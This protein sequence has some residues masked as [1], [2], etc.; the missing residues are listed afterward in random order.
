MILSGIISFLG[1]SAFRMVWGEVSAFLSK[2]Q[3]HAYEIERLKLQQQLDDAAHTRT[4]STIRLQAELGV[5][6]VQVQSA[7]E[8]EKASGDAFAAAMENA[9]KP[10]GNIVV[11]VWNGVI[12]P[13]FGTLCLALWFAKVVAQG[14]VMEDWDREL[15]AGIVGFYFADRSLGKRGK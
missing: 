11:D 1:G 4:E 10:T 14:F 5:Q 7:A 8:Q 15:L 13:S 12:R 9:F 3:D 6:Q 2:Q